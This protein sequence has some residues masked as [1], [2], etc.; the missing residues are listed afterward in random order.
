MLSDGGAGPGIDAPYPPAARRLRSES[1][2]LR[3]SAYVLA[4]VAVAPAAAALAL[5]APRWLVLVLAAGWLPL[6]G[7][8]AWL[9]FSIAF[10]KLPAVHTAP[11]TAIVTGL[12]SVETESGGYELVAVEVVAP[13]GPEVV[14]VSEPEV[15][16]AP[17]PEG[18][19][20]T[21]APGPEGAKVT[22]APGP[23]VGV[24]P[25]AGADPAYG[26]PAPATAS[27]PVAAVDGPSGPASARRFTTVIADRVHPDHLP[28]FAVGSRW[29]VLQFRH[30]TRRV[31]LAADHED[32]LR[33]GYDL[34]G[35]RLG[36][37][38]GGGT[39]YGSEL[40]ARGFRTPPAR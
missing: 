32:V 38:T 8:A 19:K 7:A 24:A 35:V 13:A 20:V 1:R 6:Q 18:A 10:R 17:G 21:E 16:E 25:G 22:E 26:A 36:A 37:E 31:V 2:L 11:R 39:G 30:S 34:G 9:A 33:T 4:V 12:T 29:Q 40:L 14:G 15:A 3:I 5:D 23:E 28:R 27:G